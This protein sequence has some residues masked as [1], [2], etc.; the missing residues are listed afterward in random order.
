M[1]APRRLSV[2]TW[3]GV[4]GAPLA[5][6]GAHVAAWWVSESNCSVG[7]AGWPLSVDAWVIALVVL[8][9]TIAIGSEGAA[10]VAFRKTRD[11]GE[12]L[13]GSRLHFLSIIGIVVGVLFL[14]LIAL[15]GLATLGLGKCVQS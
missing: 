11:A 10:I 14:T 2:L 15:N 5:W 1:T 4:L 7:T 13:P 12:G 3:Y 8:A 6:A 9:G